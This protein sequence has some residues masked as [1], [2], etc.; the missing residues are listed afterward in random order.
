MEA[1]VRGWIWRDRWLHAT[2]IH[3]VMGEPGRIWRRGGTFWRDRWLHA[4]IYTTLR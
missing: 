1:A 3:A 2:V 4:T